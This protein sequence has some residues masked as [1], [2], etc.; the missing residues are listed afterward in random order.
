MNVR[1]KCAVEIHYTLTLGDG[2]V[3]DS[4]E[5]KPPLKYLHGIGMLVPG[6]ERELEGRAVGDQLEVTVSPEEGYGPV[7]P[8][9]I[10]QV[11]REVLGPIEELAVG[12]QLEAQSPEGNVHLVIM[13]EVDGDQVTLNA[14]P[15]LAGEVLHFDIEVASVREASEQEI[16]H[17]HVHDEGGH[18]HP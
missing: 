16:E 13:Q 14:N 12:M 8:E 3:V 6:L 11:D 4:S 2:R 18:G 1:E 5:G 10:Q 9:L 7:D 17:G 15:P